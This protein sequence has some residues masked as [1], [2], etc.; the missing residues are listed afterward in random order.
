MTLVG[1]CIRAAKRSCTSKP[2][3][4]SG[5]GAQLGSE[6]RVPGG[7]MVLGN[8]PWKEQQCTE[9][10]ERPGGGGLGWAEWMALEGSSNPND[11]VILR[12][13]GV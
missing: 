1:L 8:L 3:V 10:G 4:S 7:L 6:V 11:S 12:M 5:F 13:A 9:V 2:G